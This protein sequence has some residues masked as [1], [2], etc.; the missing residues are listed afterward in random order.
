VEDRRAEVFPA[1]KDI[2]AETLRAPAGREAYQRVRRTGDLELWAVRARELERPEVWDIKDPEQWV[3]PVR[4]PEVREA[5]Q[6]V[7]GIRDLER[8][9]GRARKEPEVPAVSQQVRARKG[10]ERLVVRGRDLEL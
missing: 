2:K 1:I 8:W 4:D 9:V 6:Q 7:R 5:F 3:D 10:R